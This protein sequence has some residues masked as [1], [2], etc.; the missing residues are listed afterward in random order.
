MTRVLVAWLAAS[1]A[2]SAACE[3]RKPEVSGLGPYKFGSS[4]RAQIKS[5]VCQPTELSDGRK[6]TWCF[7]LPPVKVYAVASGHRKI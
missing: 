2:F 7:A 4:T 3:G 5:G 6:A 1:V